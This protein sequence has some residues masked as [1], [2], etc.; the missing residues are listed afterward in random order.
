MLTSEHWIPLE[1]VHELP[2][3]QALV[4]QQRRFVKPLRYDARSVSEFAN[5]LLLDVGPAAVPLHLLSPFMN[6]VERASKEGVIAATGPAAW[7]W[8]T[9]DEMPPL[10]ALLTPILG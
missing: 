7:V 4:A 5:A 10:P 3:I 1:G 6:P 8:C 9:E 2:L